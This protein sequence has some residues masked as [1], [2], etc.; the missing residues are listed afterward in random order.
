LLRP[1]PRRSKIT[2]K[3]AQRAK[4]DTTVVRSYGL[5]DNPEDQETTGGRVGQRVAG[6]LE[7]R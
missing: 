6:G 1:R 3:L 2:P 7:K 5:A 4:A